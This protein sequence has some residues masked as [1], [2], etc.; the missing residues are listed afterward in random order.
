[1]STDISGTCKNLKSS[2]YGKVYWITGLAGAGKTTLAKYLYDHWKKKK[3]NLVFLDGDILREVFG[4]SASH[5]FEERHKLAMKY[6]KLCSL[7][8]SQGLDVICATISMF[9]KC[10]EWNRSNLVNYF[11]IYIKVPL[12]VLKQRDQKKLYSRFAMGE[13]QNVMGLD[14][15]FEEPKYSDLII[16]NDGS[17]TPQE[18]CKKLLNFLSKK[19]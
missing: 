16:E 5:T 9:D 12:E 19:E 6:S 7:L 17:Q 1:M 10:R 2:D 11:E 8:S 3:T 15:E 18:L 13:I 4:D 14:L